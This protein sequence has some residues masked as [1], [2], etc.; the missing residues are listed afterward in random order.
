[1]SEASGVRYVNQEKSQS[2]S[3]FEAKAPGPQPACA[4]DRDVTSDRV[5]KAEKPD[6]SAFGEKL[7]KWR[8]LRHMS[9]NDL[10]L[11]ANVS[12][13]HISFLETGRARP[14]RKMI[15][16]L[17][18]VLDIPLRSR[19]DLLDAAGHRKSFTQ[20]SLS[21][22]CL[23]QVSAG[24]NALL[25]AHDPFPAFVMDDDWN[26][27]RANKA[28]SRL[29][30]IL[31]DGMKVPASNSANVIDWLVEE[32]GV[33]SIL[34][35]WQEIGVELVRRIHRKGEIQGSAPTRHQHLAKLVA[36]LES[37]KEPLNP[38]TQDPF[39]PVRIRKGGLELTLYS[40]VTKIADP[41]DITLQELTLQT[42]CPANSET[43][44]LLLS[45]SKLGN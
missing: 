14:S 44:Q 20:T 36:S 37:S 27:L 43:Q 11:A 13:R 23:G 15:L 25:A 22:P 32:E 41:R 17:A 5:N 12:S 29:L 18:E 31:M 39:L 6:K 38:K 40:V 34:L 21:D 35:N 30:S 33:N 45:L 1:M 4:N 42:L 28:A 3:E 8:S 2:P 16:R 10:A 24:L 19:N 7:K 26:V 9:Q